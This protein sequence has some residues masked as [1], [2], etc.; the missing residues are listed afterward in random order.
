M[1]HAS[2]GHAHFLLSTGSAC[3]CQLLGLRP[4]ISQRRAGPRS[5]SSIAP[6]AL[7]RGRHGL[8]CE[9]CSMWRSF[10]ICRIQSMYEINFDR[11]RI[12]KHSQSPVSVANLPLRRLEQLPHAHREG[13]TGPG[14]ELRRLVPHDLA[15]GGCGEKLGS[16][17]R[18]SPDARSGPLLHCSVYFW[19]G[20]EKSRQ[21]AGL[22]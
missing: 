11:G 22:C 10:R 8:G 17:F 2:V 21:S 9:S 20:W 18:A 12:S 6:L 13:K 7:Q 14:I 16:L 5:R 1:P 3:C 15:T 19:Y 4:L